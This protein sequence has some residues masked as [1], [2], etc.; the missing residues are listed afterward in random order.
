MPIYSKI[1][2]ILVKD[3][4]ELEEVSDGIETRLKIYGKIHP[5]FSAVIECDIPGNRV[6]VKTLNLEEHVN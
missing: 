3:L 4:L 1:T 6:I 2:S 5:D